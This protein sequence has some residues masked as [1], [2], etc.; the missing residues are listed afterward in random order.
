M[1][2]AAYPTAILILLFVYALTGV[3]PFQASLAAQESAF[4]QADPEEEDTE[5]LSEESEEES[6]EFSLFQYNGFIEFQS[7]F[8]TYR[9]QDFS[10]ASKKNELRTRFES[11]YGEDNLHLYV[12]ADLFY[13]FQ[14]WKDD[15]E[16]DYRYAHD[17]RVKRNLRIT[18]ED[19]EASFNELYLNFSR[20]GYR[21]RLGNQIYSWGTADGINA[22]S[23]FNPYDLREFIF[24]ED[25]EFRFG[26]PSLSGMVFRNNYTVELVFVPVNIPMRL[27]PENNFWSIRQDEI[28]YNLHFEETDG[29]DI[30]VR[31]FAYGARISSSLKGNDFSF[32]LYHGPD[33]E[34]V[35]IP[36]AV[37]VR[38]NLPVNVNIEHRYY[39]VDYIGMDFSRTINDFVV[40]A[41][42][43]YSPNKANI[44]EQD[45]P[46]M[47]VR[48]PYEV[49]RSSYI[50][51]AVGFN[52]FIPLHHLLEDHE[53]ESVFTFEWFQSRFLETG[54]SQPYLF[55]NWLTFKY[56]D[57]F[58]HGH[59]PV[60][61]TTL[62]ETDHGGII[63]RPE[64]GWDFLNGM[65]VE[66]SYAGISGKKE[67]GELV[68]NSYYNYRNNDMVMLTLRY[69]Y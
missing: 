38:P 24:R 31:N 42:I 17:S 26:V 58:Y 29:M 16:K 61:L 57:T 68:Q 46:F 32:S 51:Y 25:D 59:I 35:L 41:E 34:P 18:S 6:D 15:T 66:L 62:I 23:Y 19:A 8:N 30:K 7:F 63:F 36:M 48:F 69:E 14:H 40:Q 52:Y 47:E 45:V 56:K 44:M 13:Q 27:A 5:A 22:T 10:D 53:G 49:E 4:S 12:A 54:V 9:D 60:A 37:E 64:I 2:L 3:T 20:E 55:K 11:R 1:R 39:V 65:S 21:L 43:A 33:R 28:L 50:S 67:T